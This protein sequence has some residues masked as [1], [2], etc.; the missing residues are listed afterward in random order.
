MIK[1][2]DPFQDFILLKDT[3]KAIEEGLSQNEETG[4]VWTPKVDVGESEKSIIVKCEL[5]GV[6][7][8]D[9]KIDITGDTLSISGDKKWEDS[10][11]DVKYHK[12]ERIYG[13][14]TRTFKIG[15]PIDQENIKATYKN[16]V[17]EIVVP[18]AEK[19]AQKKI[20][21]TN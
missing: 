20:E 16:G 18:K 6:K 4:N 7:K 13:A 14:F 11:V 12:I 17:L 15:I 5:P 2:Y 19:L 3:F 10:D 8:E 9:I 21:I 1:K